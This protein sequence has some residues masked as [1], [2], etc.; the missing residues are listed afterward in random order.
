MAKSEK[1]AQVL[2]SLCGLTTEHPPWSRQEEV[3]EADTHHG[4]P[5]QTR[6]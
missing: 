4:S 2:E 3:A 6:S 1:S 5:S